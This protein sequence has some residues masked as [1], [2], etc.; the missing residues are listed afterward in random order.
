MDQDDPE[1]RIAELERQITEAK[2]AAPG[3]GNPAPAQSQ[4]P[5]P[6]MPP[7]PIGLPPGWQGPQNF[8]SLAGPGFPRA[9][10]GRGFRV[11]L[12]VSIVV[13]TTI[14]P[15]GVAAAIYLGFSSSSK[16]P[17]E[18]GS[19]T[20]ASSTASGSTASGSTASGSTASTSAA[21]GAVSVPQGGSLTVDDDTTKT[22]ACNDGKLTVQDIAVTV[23]GHCAN[24]T[25]DDMSNQVTVDSADT[26]DVSGIST[27]VTVTGRCGQL[28]VSSGSENKVVVPGHCSDVNVSSGT[29]NQVTV[30]SA[31]TIEADGIQNVIVFHTGSPKINDT[32]MNNTVKQG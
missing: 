15:V 12:V 32:G 19:G 4:W 8:G 7:P 21:S 1:K 9:G 24:L 23:T 13:L 26:I 14:V 20:T 11:G 3:Q 18:S 25:I 28:T 29:E 22:V 10:S 16:A 31:D 6:G 30:G 27:T 2:G 17:T 5:P